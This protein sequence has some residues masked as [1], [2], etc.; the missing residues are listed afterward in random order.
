MKVP[1]VHHLEQYV[2]RI[3]A[4]REVTHLVDHQNSG[5]GVRCQRLS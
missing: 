3:G 2:R 1:L 4:I 5:M